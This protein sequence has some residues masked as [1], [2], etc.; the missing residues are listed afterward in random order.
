LSDK[1]MKEMAEMIRQGAKMLSTT[2]PECG[3][4]LFQLKTGETFCPREKREVKTIKDGKDAQKLAQDASLE[5]TLQ[6]KLQ[7]LQNRLDVETEPTEIKKLTET[8]ITLLE[9]QEHL[10]PGNEKK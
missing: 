3:A 2:C 8:I 1:S 6:T 7:L 10:K 5:R 9:A 4:P